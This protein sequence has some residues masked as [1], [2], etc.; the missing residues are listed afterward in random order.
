MSQATFH[1][2][3][4]GIE[5]VVAEAGPD[6]FRHAGW[7]A[8]VNGTEYGRSLGSFQGTDDEVRQQVLARLVD[9]LKGLA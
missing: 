1:T 6:G 7:Y 2:D 5:I 9:R 4:K 8:C 3:T